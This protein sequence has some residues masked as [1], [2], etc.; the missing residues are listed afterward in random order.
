MTQLLDTNA[1]QEARLVEP[2]FYNSADMGYI[3]GACTL[4]SV[5]FGFDGT[6]AF[7]ARYPEEEA[8]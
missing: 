5:A 4:L 2:I 1:S 6:N 7:I 3:D 8:P